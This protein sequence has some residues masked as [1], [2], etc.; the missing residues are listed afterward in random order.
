MMAQNIVKDVKII[1]RIASYV[2][3]MKLAYN[4]KHYI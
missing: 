1:Y 4:V 3:I 2:I